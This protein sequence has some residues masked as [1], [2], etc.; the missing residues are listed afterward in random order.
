MSINVWV[1]IAVCLEVFEV[2]CQWLMTKKHMVGKVLPEALCFDP[3]RLPM[4][5]GAGLSPGKN[6][7]KREKKTVSCPCPKGMCRKAERQGIDRGI[8]LQSIY[9]SVVNKQCE[10]SLMRWCVSN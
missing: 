4:Q 3:R 8:L 9:L 1:H 5:P 7:T 2:L 6:F 10:V